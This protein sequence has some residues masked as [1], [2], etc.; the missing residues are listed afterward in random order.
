MTIEQ[1]YEVA[2]RMVDPSGTFKTLHPGLA[3]A[4]RTAHEYVARG[5]TPEY[6]G[7]NELRST[8]V[9]AGIIVAFRFA[10]PTASLYGA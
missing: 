9:I 6:M 1:V 8:Q 4:L 5:D 7:G 2:L 3:L 10:N